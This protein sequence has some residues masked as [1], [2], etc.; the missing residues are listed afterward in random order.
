LPQE[1][2]L[3]G[4]FVKFTQALPQR[5]GNEPPLHDIPQVGVAPA[6]VAWPFVGGGHAVHVAVPHELGDVLLEHV[7]LQSC[8]PAAQTQ[9]ELWQTFPPVQVFP[10]PPQL[11]GSLVVLISQPFAATRSQ[12][13]NPVWHVKTQLE[14]LQVGLALGMLHTR[15]Q[16]PQL[17]PSLT[18]WVSQPSAG[19]LSQSAYPAA[20]P[21]MTQIELAQPDVAWG[22]VQTVPQAPQSFTLLVVSMHSL[23]LQSVGV[24]DGQPDTH[25]EAEQMGVPPTHLTPQPPQLDGIARSVSQ[26]FEAIP[27]Q[28]ANPRLHEVIVQPPVVQPAVA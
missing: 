9:A 8:V 12:S 3:P 22:A 23:P 26:P 17:F 28:S 18:V 2:Q 11:F 1:P 27:S 20:H 13:A 10:H 15:P 5:F 25:P 6:Q 14:A 7:P 21:A 24:A 4:S 19:N 16:L